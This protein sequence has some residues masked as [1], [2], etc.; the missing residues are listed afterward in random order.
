MF[1]DEL[2]DDAPIEQLPH[3]AVEPLT[4]SEVD[5][6]KHYTQYAVGGKPLE[7]IDVLEALDLPFHLA[8]AMKYIWRHREKGGVKDLEKAR[9]YLDRYIAKQ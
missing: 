3:G 9:W 2:E 7:C 5:H 6:P 8:N 4:P 1:S